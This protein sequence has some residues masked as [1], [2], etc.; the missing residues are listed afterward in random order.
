SR[1][2]RHYQPPRPGCPA[3]AHSPGDTTVT[4]NNDDLAM[5][6]HQAQKF[7]NETASPERLKALLDDDVGFDRA[8]WTAA[9]DLGWPLLYAPEF[10]A[11]LDLG[12]PG[13]ASLAEQLGRKCLSLPLV[14]AFVCLEAVAC[15]QAAAPELTAIAGAMAERSAID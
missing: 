7:L 9:V 5:I 6:R 14:P 13:L 10:V 12:L 2:R 8:A 1:E 15:R 3:A 11:A 4:D